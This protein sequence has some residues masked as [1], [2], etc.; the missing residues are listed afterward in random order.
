MSVVLR[1][2]YDGSGKADDPG[3]PFMTLG[4]WIG[5]DDAIADFERRWKLVLKQYGHDYVHMREAFH[6]KGSFA[7]RKREEFRAFTNALFN[8]C[9]S[10]IEW[11]YRDRFV[12]TCCTVNL[13]DYRRAAEGFPELTKR[14]KAEALC[15]DYVVHTALRLLPEDLSAPYGKTGVV[16]L[17]FDRTEPFRHTIQRAWDRWRTQG[18][19]PFIASIDT[20]NAREDILLQAADVLAWATSRAY[21]EGYDGHARLFM[22]I[23][24]IQHQYYDYDRIVARLKKLLDDDR[25]TAA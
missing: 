7:G 10:K 17:R 13:A 19:F 4:G 23:C 3:C 2:Y 1:A 11:E 22:G 25:D 12:G 24:R 20:G 16:R 6:S 18:V 8:D 9:V 21:R 15:V 5:A 14:K